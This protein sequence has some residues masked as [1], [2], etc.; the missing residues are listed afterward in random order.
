M[1]RGR[2]PLDALVVGDGQARLAVGYHLARRGMRFLLVEAVP[3]SSTPGR[4]VGLA[5]ALHPRRV[6]L[7]AR[8]GVPRRA[9]D[10]PGQGPGR[11]L[12]EGLRGPVRPL[13]M[14]RTRVQH[15][16]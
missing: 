2:T 16:D 1:N 6:L 8:H 10:L 12:P 15:V 3:S 9:R 11:G 5:T 14:P 4:P 13:V 7:V